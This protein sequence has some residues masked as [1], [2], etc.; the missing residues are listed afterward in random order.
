[1]PEDHAL[2]KH[3]GHHDRAGHRNRHA[4]DQARNPAPPHQVEQ[5]RQHERRDRALDQGARHDHFPHREHL[6][7]VKAQAN[8]KE[9][10]NDADLG[11]MLGHRA[12]G[13]KAWREGANRNPGQQVA[14]NGRK[15]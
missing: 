15:L 5:Q 3:Q 13:D 10:Q 14:D 7:Q 9:Q 6:A 11:E 4:Q 12:I 1:V 2:A 8:A